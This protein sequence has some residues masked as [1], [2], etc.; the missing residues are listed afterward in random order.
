MNDPNEVCPGIQK[1]IIE[2][3]R[4][5]DNDKVLKGFNHLIGNAFRQKGSHVS[6]TGSWDYGSSTIGFL[7]DNRSRKTDEGFSYSFKCAETASSQWK[8]NRDSCSER[9]DDTNRYGVCCYCWKYRYKLFE[10]CRQEV[11]FRESKTTIKGA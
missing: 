1:I 6:R 3:A 9:K 10:M 2:Q 4:I 5:D 7:F 8:F 11:G